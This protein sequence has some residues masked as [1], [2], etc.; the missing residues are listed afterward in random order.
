MSTWNMGSEPHSDGSRDVIMAFQNNDA[1]GQVAGTLTFKNT[2]YSVDGNWAAAGSV[3]GRN[4]S[5]FALWGSDNQGATQY[6]AAT[7]TLDDSSGSLKAIQLNL[8]RVSTGDDRQFGWDGVLLP[9]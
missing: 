6:V 2:A 3:T 9:M 5:A 7:G 8:I 4:Y 1:N